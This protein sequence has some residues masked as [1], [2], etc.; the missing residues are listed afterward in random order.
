MR[1]FACMKNLHAKPAHRSGWSLCCRGEVIRFG[2]RRRQCILCSQTWRVRKK[3]RGR[4]TK[5]TSK[6]L[7]KKYINREIPTLYAL[8]RIRNGKSEDQRQREMKRSLEQFVKNT[9]WPEL[10]SGEPLIAV[11]DAMIIMV[12]KKLYSFYF[13]L[14]RRILDKEAVIAPLYVCEGKESYPGW[15]EAF[16]KLPPATL[17]S[18][19]ALVCDSHI[20]LQYVARQKGWIM[21]Q[22][23]F[24]LI[25]RI[26]GRRSRWA[27]SKHRKTGEYLYQLVKEAITNPDEEAILDTIREIWEAGQTTSSKNLKTY[28][29]G[30]TRRYWEYRSYLQYPELHLPRTSNS[31]ESLIGSVRKLCSRAHGFRTIRSLK[32]WVIALLK[33]KK[34]ATCN[35]ALPTKLMR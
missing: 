29:S 3:K 12:D 4:K 8:A 22:C 20:G 13:I 21:Q 25:A 11:A 14:V 30:F 28:L 7:F 26:Q 2:K 10:P 32:L 16:A 6:E 19:Y 15:W 9:P 27:Q 18:I 5:R 35:G 24:H 33:K 23:N 31:A 1:K 34:V 17:A